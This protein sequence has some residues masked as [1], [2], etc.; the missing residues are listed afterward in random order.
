MIILFCILFVFLNIIPFW[1]LVC[2]DKTYEQR[3]SI[4]RSKNYNRDKFDK[5]S[6]NKHLWYLVTFR[7]P[8]RLYK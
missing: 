3:V 7:N 1:V 6:Y 8:K 4:I 2:N 5:V